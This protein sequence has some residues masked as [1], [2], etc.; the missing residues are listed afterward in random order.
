VASLGAALSVLYAALAGALATLSHRRLLVGVGVWS[1]VIC[2]FLGST[3]ILPA[4]V[5][6]GWLTVVA[7]FNPVNYAIEAARALVLA[8]PDYQ[9]YTHDLVLLCCLAVAGIIVAML[10][11]R[12]DTEAAW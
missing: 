3:L 11:A 9:L 1:L 7:G 5:L 12:R 10:A 6:P 4:S 8:H 2:S